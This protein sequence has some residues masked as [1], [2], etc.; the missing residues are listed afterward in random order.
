MKAQRM[1]LA[2]FAGRICVALSVA[3]IA[4]ALSMAAPV[5]AAGPAVYGPKFKVL[6]ATLMGV[7]SL[8]Q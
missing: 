6:P 7:Q 2:R 4:T 8:E 3:R 5:G 1:S